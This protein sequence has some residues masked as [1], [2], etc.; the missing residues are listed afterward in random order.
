MVKKICTWAIEY[1]H[2][3]LGIILLITAFFCYQIKNVVIKTELTD[4]YP[5]NHPFIK[6][7]EKYKDQLGSP[8][9]VFMM[10][11]VKEGDIYNKKTLG[12]VIRITDGLDAIPGVNHNH[13]YSIA[14]RKIKKT[15]VT[16]DAIISVNLMDGIPE[17]MEEFRESVRT[18]GGVYGVWVSRDEKSVLF[19]AAFIERLMDYDTIFEGVQKLIK[20]ESDANHI[21]YAAGEPVLMGW[22]NTNLQEMYYIFTIVESP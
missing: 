5:P 9:K 19:T 14:S 18:A 3:T 13:V 12:K 16:K 7:H 17:S 4:L 20:S 6:I 2:I 22:V 11:Q 15:S 8:F 10:L 1:R 21:V